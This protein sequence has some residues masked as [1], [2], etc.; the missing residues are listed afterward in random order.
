MVGKTSYLKALLS[1]EAPIHSWQLDFFFPPSLSQCEEW[2]KC[3]PGLQ[4]ITK[5]CSGWN[6]AVPQKE[7]LATEAG[8]QEEA[9]KMSPH[10]DQI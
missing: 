9:L 4:F 8:G 3:K 1:A 5:Q 7:E 10:L 6:L 2:Q